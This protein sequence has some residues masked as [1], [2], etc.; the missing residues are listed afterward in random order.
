[1]VQGGDFENGDGTGGL[2]EAEV[3]QLQERTWTKPARASGHLRIRGICKTSSSHRQQGLQLL[4]SQLSASDRRSR[5]ASN[6][7]WSVRCVPRPLQQVQENRQRVERRQP[8]LHGALHPEQGRE[9]EARQKCGRGGRSS[10]PSD[11]TRRFSSKLRLLSCQQPQ[12][13]WRK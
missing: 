9:Q 8:R 3:G 7:L 12:R 5:P 2:A 10:E 4:K 13:L 1:M 6:P 11:G